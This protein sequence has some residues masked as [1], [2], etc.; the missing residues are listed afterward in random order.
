MFDWLE[1]PMTKGEPLSPGWA[2][3]NYGIA[4]PKSVIF[5]PSCG[6]GYDGAVHDEKEVH[7]VCWNCHRRFSIRIVE[8][9]NGKVYT[10]VALAIQLKSGERIYLPLGF[11]VKN[12]VVTGESKDGQTYF[13]TFRNVETGQ[14][15]CYNADAPLEDVQE[16]L[17]SMAEQKVE[18]EQQEQFDRQV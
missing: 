12:T 5:C 10:D 8:M 6:R 18:Q 9:L 15:Y 2:V 17:Q 7:L 16:A 14:E 4:V 13:Y 11:T 1:V 3:G